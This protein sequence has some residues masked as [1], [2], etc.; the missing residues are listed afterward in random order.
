MNVAYGGTLHQ[1]LHEVPGFLDHRDDES[2]PLD[3]Q[4]GPAHDVVLEEGGLLRAIAGAD[5]IR[6]NSLHHQG[7]ERL[8]DRL[9]VEARAPDGVVEAFRVRGEAFRRR[10]AVA[11]GMES[12]EQR[13]FQ[14]AVRRLRRVGTRARTGTPLSRK[15]FYMANEIQQFFRD[16]RHFRSGS[17][18]S[19]HGRHRARQD[20]AR[21]EIRGRRRHAAAG[22]HLPADGDRRLP[23]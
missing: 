3:V 17:H 7:V 12:N 11:P 18:H 1:N 10:R 22:E 23:A 2:Q 4:Y 16:H 14:S 21:R 19:R 8:S 5:R 6:V 9:V 13:F 15:V 20:H